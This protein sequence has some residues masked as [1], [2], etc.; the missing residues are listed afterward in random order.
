VA[1]CGQDVLGKD[2]FVMVLLDAG[3]PVIR[4]HGKVP[5]VNEIISRCA[6]V[7]CGVPLDISR[8]GKPGQAE[9]HKIVGVNIAVC[10]EVTN[11]DSY[12]VNFPPVS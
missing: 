10:V 3:V 1:Q 2:H 5:R 6:N 4:K 8:P 11:Q 12:K 7:T 9:Q